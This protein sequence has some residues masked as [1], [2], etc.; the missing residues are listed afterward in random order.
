MAERV[1]L[2]EGKDDRHVMWNLF[3]VRHVPRVFEVECPESDRGMDENGGVEK[4]L[5]TIPRRLLES[6][7]E[8]LA[9]V[10]DANDK[11]PE[12][13]WRQI[14][15]RLLNRGYEGV[16]DE[17]PQGGAVELS[18]RPRSPRSVRLAVWVMPDNQS[19]GVLED[20]VVKL[21]R[22]DD[23]TL[24]YIDRF[25]DSIPV[26]LQRFKSVHRSKARIHSWLAIS[27]RPGRPMGQAIKADRQLDA[28]SPAVEPFLKWINDALITDGEQP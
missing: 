19:N 9:V 13:R 21:I 17:L 23:G 25:L 1:L 7:I 8:R 3:E 6:D 14:R 5:E 24:P 2:V 27:E 28:N 15:D 20:F 11:G 16:P 26:A 10:V 18:L 12:F 4:L 22:E